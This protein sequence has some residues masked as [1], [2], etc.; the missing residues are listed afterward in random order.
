MMVQD[1][2]LIVN[3]DYFIIQR[4]GR[5]FAGTLTGK[6][7]PIP[8]EFADLLF[9]TF[10]KETVSRE[11]AIKSFLNDH[12]TSALIGNVPVSAIESRL[13]QLIQAGLIV[14][15]GYEPTQTL[16]IHE[17]IKP[18]KDSSYELD[19]NL[20]YQI[21]R[22]F[23]FQLSD[24]GYIVNFTAEQRAY[25]IEPECL[26]SLLS[27]T[28]TDNL[29]DSVKFKNPV[30]SEAEHW[31][32]IRWFIEQGL[33]VAKRSH[34][35]KEA[36]EQQLLPQKPQASTQSWQELQ[37]LDKVPVYFVPHTENHYPLAL[38]LIYTALQDFDG[39][40]LVD[41]IQLIPITYL[42]PQEFLQGPYR[43]F[44]AGIW[45]FSNYLWSEETN[46]AMSKFIKQDSPRNITIHGG[47]S[48]PD[49][50]EKCE[51]FFV[52]NTSVDIAVHAEGEVSI[53]EVLN[54]LRVDGSNFQM[55]FNSL[56]LVEGISYRDYSQGTSQ[57]VHTAKRTRMKDPN[58]IP[59]P[60][61]AGVFD[62]YGDDV[63]AAI[64]ESN[65]GCP[66]GCTFCDWGSA[67]N[68]KVRKFDMDRVKQ[69]IEWI[70]QHQSKVLWIADANFGIYDRDIEVAEYIIE[71]KE[72]Y[73]FP[74]EVVVNYTKNTTV[75]LVDIIKVFS[76]GG[77]IS[78][79]VI[80]I[81]TMDTQTLEVID[82]KNIKLGKYEELRDI[83]MDLKLPLSTDLMLGLPGTSMEALKN[84]LQ[85]YIDADVPV[86]AYPTQLLPNS[87][88]ADPEYM[89]K[90]KIETYD[91][92]YLKST[93][94]YTEAD[95][96]QMKL[97]Y[98]VFTMCDG[99]GLLRYVI[100]F[101]QWEYNIRAID[102]IYDLMV[103]LQTTPEPYPRLTFA[104]RFFET[105]KCVPSG[106]SEFYAELKRYVL[107]HYDV[108]DDSAFQTVL[109]VNQAVM[110]EESTTYPLN[111]TTEHNFEFYFQRR[112]KGEP[113]S[114]SE[115]EA[116]EITISDPD[117]MIGIDD[118]YMQ[119]DSHQFF[120]ELTSPVSRIRSAFTI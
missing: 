120:W 50:P 7:Q 107:D 41:K 59:S 2:K 79:G 87:P 44:G 46:L 114:L 31:A 80:S 108:S 62:H 54:A 23:A 93:Y 11:T 99:Y 104:M 105:D 28:Q 111:M 15:E 34:A 10:F 12:T 97:L 86:K 102:F 38:G 6:N 20:G 115:L 58:V 40:S 71:M 45:L 85:H 43:K 33:I 26:F 49:Y 4:N 106:W 82:R 74:Q 67:I 84:D 27:V 89:R 112:Q 5:F 53:S 39:G 35:D 17:L 70:A 118:S 78:Q 60:Y 77:I 119:Y 68:Q 47:P 55:D 1:A 56:K 52:K 66:F 22:N 24:K 113:V 48:T 73:G 8:L 42:E 57:I 25:L 3:T 91:D 95:L 81:Q 63:E 14:S 88:M 51:E 90:Y 94:S 109:M 103:R 72:K 36:V 19:E 96:E 65:R 30:I 75:R 116:G 37:K 92:G 69:E 98:K 76:D 9:L 117:G 29:K 83:F 18:H 101:L 32:F 100:R 21:H 13:M 64:I 110:P 61:M 16:N